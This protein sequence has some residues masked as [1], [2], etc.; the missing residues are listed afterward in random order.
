M[1]AWELQLWMARDE[2]NN[3]VQTRQSKTKGMTYGQALDM[4]RADF[5][6]HRAR[7]VR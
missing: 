6:A 1:G 7:K 4:V 2:I 3:L 5:R